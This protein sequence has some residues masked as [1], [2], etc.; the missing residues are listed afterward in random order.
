[1]HERAG[2]KQ[3]LRAVHVA[4]HGLVHWSDPLACALALT[5]GGDLDDG[6]L[7]LPEVFSTPIDADVV[8]LS[9]CDTGLGPV[10]RGEG[11]M[12]FARAFLLAGAARVIVSL[13]RVD[14]AATGALMSRFYDHLDEGKH[15]AAALA[16]A[17]QWTSEQSK[18]SHPRYWAGWVLWGLAD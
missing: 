5:P 11:P 15:A 17:Q 3:R 1:L 8:V 13:W 14:D 2:A 7:T 9:A 10:A 16:A 4:C 6:Y 18:W 12:G